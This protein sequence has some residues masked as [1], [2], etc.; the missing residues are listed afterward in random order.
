MTRD[1]LSKAIVCNTEQYCF[2]D[3]PKFGEALQRAGNDV[4]LKTKTPGKGLF[5][6]EV[7]SIDHLS[8]QTPGRFE[9][10]SSESRTTMADK[11]IAFYPHRRN[12]EGSYDSLCLT[13][14]V[15]I[16][17]GKS[18]AEL[19]NLDTHHVC[20]FSTLS[21]RAMNRNVP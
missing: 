15:T 9:S 6:F 13:C 16:A 14:F 5:F 3:K 19:M 8:G 4:A 12:K 11:L 10:S 2:L 1:R 7:C 18:E 17:F 20:E 21:Q